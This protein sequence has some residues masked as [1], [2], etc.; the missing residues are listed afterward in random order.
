ML[1][2]AL[3]VASVVAFA[4]VVILFD[5]DDLVVAPA[6]YTAFFTP[7]SYNVTASAYYI[8]LQSTENIKFNKN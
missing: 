3:G 7:S 4:E 6:H 5:T 8:W 2:V 1:I